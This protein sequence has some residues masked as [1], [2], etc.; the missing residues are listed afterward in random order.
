MVGHAVC[1]SLFSGIGVT[2]EQV[3]HYGGR[4]VDA[5]NTHYCICKNS[6]TGSYCE[7]EVNHC[8]HSLCRNGGTCRSFVGG[9]V[10]E[11][12]KVSWDCSR[13]W[14]LAF[15]QSAGKG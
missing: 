9:Y 12:R 3:C 1:N 2:K 7:S 13:P 14:L 5:G 4:C 15:C 10:C 8:Q 6:Y 11:V